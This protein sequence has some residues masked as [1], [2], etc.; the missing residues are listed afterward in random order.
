MRMLSL[1]CALAMALGH[2]AYGADGGTGGSA[3]TAVERGR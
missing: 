2:A 3:E 1:A